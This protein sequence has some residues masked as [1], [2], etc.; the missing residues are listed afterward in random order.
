VVIRTGFEVWRGW[1]PTRSR[2]TLHRLRARC[3]TRN[4]RDENR[5]TIRRICLVA[6][7]AVVGCLVWAA[8]AGAD[9]VGVA[10]LDGSGVEPGLVS[11]ARPDGATIGG[12][13]VLGGH[14]YW[15][16]GATHTI[17]R[18]NLDG[19][20]VEPDFIHV[21]LVDGASSGPGS[22][23]V[24]SEAIYW[25]THGYP[26][27]P[28]PTQF[29]YIGRANLDGSGVVPK[30]ISA[31]TVTGLAADDAHVYWTDITARAIG[32]A[33]LG[34]FKPEFITTGQ[35]IPAGV[36][37][38][39]THVYWAIQCISPPR[40]CGVI[41][42]ANLDGSDIQPRFITGAI[43]P[44]AL[45]VGGGYI[46]WTK[47]DPPLGVVPVQ[48]AD[49]ISRAN[50]DG[51]GIQ[52]NLITVGWVYLEGIAVDGT[53]VYWTSAPRP[54][55]ASR[56][57]CS[58]TEVMAGRSTTCTATVTDTSPTPSTPT[59]TVTFAT[60]RRGT[61]S[62][63][64][65]TLSGSGTSAACQVRYTPADSLFN[66]T[67]TASYG[68]DSTHTASTA[69]TPLGVFVVPHITNVSQSARRWLRGSALPRYAR[70]GPPIGTTFRFTTN[71]LAE[72][73]FSFTHTV[74]GRLVGGKCVPVTKQ[75]SGKPHCRRPAIAATLRHIDRAGKHSLHFEGRIDQRRWL[76][77]GPYTLKITAIAY[78]R[79]SRPATLRFT[80][81]RR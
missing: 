41:G 40:P 33:G 75:N 5:I 1:H 13:A 22:L 4:R 7:I 2:L 50:L 31:G 80:I 24:S 35:G 79:R 71:Q 77:P 43:Y 21:P 11:V 65:C 12:I 78:A 44:G 81:L 69:S 58:P 6:A 76:A 60:D 57:T 63:T 53:H 36:A 61:F 30:L 45:A 62:A 32:R 3:V 38:D 56:L 16:N 29:S 20:G 28:F 46:F 49:T 9:A 18:A 72:V 64:S 37:V 23:A 39:G 59:G 42:R 68:G 54:T 70:A 51:S 55:S 66:H 19:S 52:N 8:G 67:I 26:P 34:G 27:G 48:T 10:K 73:V 14:I 17:E 15:A 74:T 47:R 25:T